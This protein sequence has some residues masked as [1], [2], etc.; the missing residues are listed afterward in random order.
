[1]T[2]NTNARVAAV[3]ILVYLAA[4]IS[5]MAVAGTTAALLA[6]VQSFCALLLGVTFYAITREQDPHLALVALG[7]RFIEAVPG[8][9]EIYFAVGSTIFSWLLLRG[10]MIPAGLAWLGVIAS[11]GLA[12]LLAVQIAGFLGGPRNWASPLTWA[13]WSPMLVFELALAAW[14]IT[15]GIARPAGST[16]TQRAEHPAL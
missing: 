12:L 10:R 6:V 15:K 9:G 14:L 4:G 8:H 3:A 13:A 5:S 11:V 2:L 7:C 1:M 16:A